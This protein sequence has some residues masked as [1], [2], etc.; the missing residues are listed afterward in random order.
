M[1][2]GVQGCILA[3]LI[4]HDEEIPVTV[5]PLSQSNPLFFILYQSIVD[6]NFCVPF[7]VFL[8]F[9]AEKINA[10][11]SFLYW[12]GIILF[13][14]DLFLFTFFRSLIGNPSFPFFSFLPFLS[15]HSSLSIS[16][17]GRSGFS[18][19]FALPWGDSAVLC[20]GGKD[21]DSVL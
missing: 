2:S 6:L 7:F 21:E 18:N 20:F 12:S 8:F 11:S 3:T 1:D 17:F 10:L 15:F 4:L 16:L 5:S 9:Q 13:S 19:L 14:S